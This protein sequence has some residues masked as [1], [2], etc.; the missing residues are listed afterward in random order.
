MSCKHKFFGHPF[1]LEG[2]SGLIP[3]WKV[4]T[5]IVGT[6]NPEPAWH[7]ANA[8]NYYYGRAT[9]YFWEVLPRFAGIS[10]V[11]R[12]DLVAQLNFLKI[13]EIGVTDLLISIDDADLSNMDHVER[14][15]TVLDSEIELFNQ[16]TW[17]TEPIVEFILK[18]N[19]EAVYFTKWE[20]LQKR[21][22]NPI[23][24]KNRCE[25]SS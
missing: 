14:I 12:Q 19:I 20:I 5:L 2:I 21:R 24:L 1:H 6:F 10:S 15:R 22:R 13:N 18:N 9:N 11:S 17:N 23:H 16:F 7:P 3:N 25:L 4:R 8:A